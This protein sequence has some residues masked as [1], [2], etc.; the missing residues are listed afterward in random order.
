MLF[1]I[2]YLKMHTQI[3]NTLNS[4]LNKKEVKIGNNKK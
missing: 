2:C 1:A 3:P 4:V